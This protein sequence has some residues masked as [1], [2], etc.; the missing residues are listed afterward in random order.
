MAAEGERRRRVI[1]GGG[2]A[3]EDGDRGSSSR[4][5][6]FEMGGVLG[7]EGIRHAGKREAISILNRSLRRR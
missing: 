5:Q 3:R 2:Q 7:E 4:R 6:A 1:G